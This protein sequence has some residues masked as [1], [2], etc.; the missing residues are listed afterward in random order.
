MDRQ[1]TAPVTVIRRTPARGSARDL[2][3]AT[4][5]DTRS[6]A[7]LID[8]T[9]A[10]NARA[11]GVLWE[12]HADGARRAAWAISRS[13]DPDDLVS[14][15]FA[16]IL[17]A[18]RNGRGPKDAFPSYL[19]AVLRNTAARWGSAPKEAPVDFLDDLPLEGSGRWADDLSDRSQL[20]S[21][22]RALPESW[23]TVLWYTE[24]EGM[25]PR[26][27]AILLGIS[28]NGASALASRARK[29]LRAAWLQVD[30]ADSHA[31]VDAA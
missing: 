1:V 10:G 22:F 5:R 31:G 7:E 25:K 13:I 6:D 19:G 21:V 30:A 29:G 12:R 20:A 9:R 4:Q 23:R 18:I 15:A 17:L 24:V 11:Y 27:V 8:A 3:G 14:E 16:R 28:A 26:D 2:R